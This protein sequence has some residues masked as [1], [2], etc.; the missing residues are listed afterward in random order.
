MP[1]IGLFI[2]LIAGT[3]ISAVTAAAGRAVGRKTG[4]AAALTRWGVPIALIVASIWMFNVLFI[5]GISSR[6][7]WIPRIICLLIAVI[8]MIRPIPLLFLLTIFMGG[9]CY[10]G[11]GFGVPR[12]PLY[13]DRASQRYSFHIGRVLIRHGIGG[14]FPGADTGAESG[15]ITDTGGGKAGV[16]V[17]ALCG[18]GNP[19]YRRRGAASGKRRGGVP[20][21]SGTA[22]RTALPLRGVLA[23]R[24]EL[25]LLR[26]L[27]VFGAVI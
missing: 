17:L 1:V 22:R 3:V 19:P 5:F 24:E 25:F 23:Q 20:A 18:R 26:K 27:R 9:S 14:S 11:S 13:L 15:R 10:M 21:D 16:P 6:L 12:T 8:C 4:F 2:G 7:I